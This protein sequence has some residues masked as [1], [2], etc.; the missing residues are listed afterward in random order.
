MRTFHRIP[1]GIVSI[2]LK[3]DSRQMHKI[4]KNEF[5]F[6]FQRQGRILSLMPTY[7][8]S[9]N[10]NGQKRSV[11]KM[12]HGANINVA[13]FIADEKDT[14][15]TLE[16][17]FEKWKVWHLINPNWHSISML[18]SDF[19]LRIRFYWHRSCFPTFV[20]FLRDSACNALKI[21]SSCLLIS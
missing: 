15:K 6:S 21:C 11:V 9:A 16:G 12:F 18:K 20:V 13:T 14:S 2:N 19:A 3:C 5:Y 10:S 17:I 8:S 1:N 4:E 7:F